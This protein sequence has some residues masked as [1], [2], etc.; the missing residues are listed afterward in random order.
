[1]RGWTNAC[2]MT[3]WEGSKQVLEWA[4][5]CEGMWHAPVASSAERG[6][7]VILVF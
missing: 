5:M 7:E 4:D 6:R 2:F 3:D 1:M